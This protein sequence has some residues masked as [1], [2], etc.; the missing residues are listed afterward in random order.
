MPIGSVAEAG[1]ARK[2]TVAQQAHIAIQE[3]AVVGGEAPR[4]GFRGRLLGDRIFGLSTLGLA[5]VVLGLLIGLAMVLI[6]ASFSALRQFGLHFLISTD[7][8]PVNDVY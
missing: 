1:V 7:W 5:L 3:A 2:T 4:S 6:Q 8:D